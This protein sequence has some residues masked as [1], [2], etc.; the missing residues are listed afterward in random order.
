[1]TGFGTAV[2]EAPG[3]RI[4]VEIRGVNQRHLDVKIAAPREYASWEAEIRDRVR[5]RDGVVPKWHRF[6]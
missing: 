1:M 3:A 2:A 4:T 6:E 5:T